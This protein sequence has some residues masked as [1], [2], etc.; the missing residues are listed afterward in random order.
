[1]P[2]ASSGPT[3]SWRSTHRRACRSVSCSNMPGR[4]STSWATGRRH[5]RSSRLPHARP[6]RHVTTRF[7]GRRRS[8]SVGSWSRT[9]RWARPRR[10]WPRR[11]P[12]SGPSHSPEASC[13]RCR[14]TPARSP[15]PARPTG[16]SPSPERH[17]RSRGARSSSTRSVRR[18]SSLHGPRSTSATTS[19]RSVT[20]PTAPPGSPRP[21][22]GTPSRTPSRRRPRHSPTSGSRA[23]RPSS[24]PSS[25][26]SARS[27]ASPAGR[28]SRSRSGGSSRRRSTPPSSRGSAP[29]P[30]RS[31]TPR[32]WRSRRRALR[33]EAA[34]VRRTPRTE[35]RPAASGARPQA[36]STVTVFARFRGWSTFRPRRRAMR[37]ARS[38]SGIT[39]RIAERNAGAL[40]T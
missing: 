4:P 3:A 7:A 12:A 26:G 27:S 21:G 36:Y 18:R 17:W 19:E 20:P 35:P 6:R 14:T 28:S 23:M 13:G 11:S 22:T 24:P 32:P 37:Y 10:S 34:H 25:T 1:M 29:A 33:W 40:G 30:R 15:S 31:T 2:S 38:W 16:R 8:V 5:G 39:A 9:A